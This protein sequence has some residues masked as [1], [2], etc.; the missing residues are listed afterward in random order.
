VH[1]GVDDRKGQLASDAAAG[2]AGAV[3]IRRATLS[4]R[5]HSGSSVATNRHR[6][7]LQQWLACGGVDAAPTRR[8]LVAAVRGRRLHCG[9]GGASADLTRLLS[10]QIGRQ[11]AR[12]DEEAAGRQW[13]RV[14]QRTESASAAR[15]AVRQA[16]GRLPAATAHVSTANSALGMI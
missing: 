5:V 7:R 15:A 11:E 16:G 12:E 10:E 14:Q 4:V 8:V 13:G 1:Q 6:C 9:S 3:R 2:E